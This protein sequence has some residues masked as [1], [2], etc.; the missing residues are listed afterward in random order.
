MQGYLRF[1]LS[2]SGPKA[3]RNLRETGPWYGQEYGQV[4]KRK[5]NAKKLKQVNWR[6]Y[7]LKVVSTSFQLFNRLN[8]EIKEQKF[9]PRLQ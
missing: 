1:L 6:I 3:F 8:F 4:H 9:W 5:S 2:L 7:I